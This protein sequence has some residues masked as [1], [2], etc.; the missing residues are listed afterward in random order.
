MELL[1]TYFM[2]NILVLTSTRLRAAVRLVQQ[3]K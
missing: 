3:E 1:L 2:D